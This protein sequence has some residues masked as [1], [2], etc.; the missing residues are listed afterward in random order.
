M[1]RKTANLIRETQ[2][3]SI[4]HM[5]YKVLNFT[6]VTLTLKQAITNSSSHFMLE[7][8]TNAFIGNNL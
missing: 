4:E 1:V 6:L 2:L 8:S 7:F 5:H 3:F